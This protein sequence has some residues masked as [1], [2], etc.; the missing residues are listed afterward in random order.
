[1][2]YYVSEQKNLLN[3]KLKYIT[4]EGS[5]KILKELQTQGI[6]LDTETTGLDCHTDK[7]LLLQMGNRDIQVVVDCTTIDIQNY[8]ELLENYPLILQNAKFDLKFLYKLNI[9]P[10]GYLW[11]T[12]L[13]EQ[14]LYNGLEPKVNLLYLVDK[15]CG[16]I[17]DKSIRKNIPKLGITYDVIIYAAKDIEF[18]HQIKDYQRS[19]G[20]K[21]G[22]L[23]AI[24]LENRF[25][26]SLAYVEFCGL[27]LDR[28]KWTK[29]YLSAKSLLK[30]VTKKL[31]NFIISNN[32]IKYIDKQMDLFSTS[33]KT[34]INWSST[35]QVKPFFK[36][37]GI[38]VIVD[39]NKSGESISEKV[40]TKQKDK[41]PIIET[42]LEY[43][44]IRKDF[45][46]YGESFLE[47][48]NPITGRIHTDFNQLMVT[49]RLSSNNP[50]LQ[51]LPRD[52]RTRSCFTNQHD[53]TI[54]VIA[55]YS[56]QED[57][58]FVNRSKEE[59]MIEFYKTPDQD[60]HSYVAKL[61]F[62]DE[63]KDIPLQN[64]KKIRPDLRFKAKSAKFAI[65]YSGVGKTIANNLNIS[66]DEGNR[67]YNSYMR[68]FP[69][70]AK[71]LREVT[72]KAKNLGYIV[73]STITNRK[74]W[75][76][77]FD[78]IQKENDFKKL[79]EFSKLAC[80]YP[81]QTE[82]AEM[83]KISC[84]FLFDWILSTN[85]FNRIK[86]ANLIHD[87]IMCECPIE[88]STVVSDKLKEYMEKAGSFYCKV[89]PLKAVPEISTTW[90]H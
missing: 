75:C 79:Y 47:H 82:G 33:L 17:L 22:V 31:N 86:I 25:V 63:L 30:D 34:T 85:N 4:I 43:Q 59:K 23:R 18:L 69:D 73:T 49:S 77:N 48:I 58:V 11:D 70:I 6:A 39:N 19:E 56:G 15:Y 3:D 51:N 71:Y 7:I 36:D 42:Y 64:I 10:K 1:M 9:I 13:A 44:T 55:D 14:V 38:N 90:K 37:I 41:S 12:M 32:Y 89:I 57:I 81:I 78:T 45:S 80:N 66:L 5:L 74:V 83:T 60:G 87:E 35:E 27:Y 53:D 54:L 16:E 46:T 76:E 21:K 84:I 65:H 40:L 72:K 2:I 62:V 29:K 61:C 20:I 67:I 88:L 52:E 50:N 28:N 68:A 26:R 24:D 8:K